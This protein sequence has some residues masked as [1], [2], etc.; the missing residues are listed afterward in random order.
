MAILIDT[1]VLLDFLLKRVDFYDDATSI[2]SLARKREYEFRITALTLGTAYY[3]IRKQFSHVESIQLLQE[4][5]SVFPCVISSNL[6]CQDALFM[7]LGDFEDALQVAMA[8][9]ECDM[10]VTRNVADFK[11]SGLLVISPKDFLRMHSQNG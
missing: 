9:S 1:N 8:K 2:V 4:F 10:I 5:C 11:H 3:I 6:A 7:G